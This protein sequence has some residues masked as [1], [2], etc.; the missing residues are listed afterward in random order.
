MPAEFDLEKIKVKFLIGNKPKPSDGTLVKI[1]Q[2][3]KTLSKTRWDLGKA[4]N[5]IIINNYQ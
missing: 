5:F 3:N 1:E 4:S 2:N